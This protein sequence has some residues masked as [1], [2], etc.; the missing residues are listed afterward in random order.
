[1]ALLESLRLT[2]V[3]SLQFRIEAFNIFNHAQFFG[4]PAVDGNIAGA[5]FGELVNS[6]APRLVQAGAKF[7]FRALSSSQ[8]PIT[9]PN[10]TQVL[11]SNFIRNNCLMG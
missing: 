5:T 10:G 9:E 11:P 6:A 4:P 7:T 8:S 2:E 3:K 1:M